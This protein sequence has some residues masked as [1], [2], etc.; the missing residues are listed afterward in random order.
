MIPQIIAKNKKAE[1]MKKVVITVDSA[2]DLPKDIAEKYGIGIMPMNVIINGEEKKDGV[3]ITA[4]ERCNSAG[5]PSNG[6]CIIFSL[7][8]STAFSSFA[9]ATPTPMEHNALGLSIAEKVEISVLKTFPAN[10]IDVNAIA[11]R[12]ISVSASSNA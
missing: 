7:A 12:A 11:V 1:F 5:P 6:D 3:N 9:G 10:K 8:F 2:A 4:S